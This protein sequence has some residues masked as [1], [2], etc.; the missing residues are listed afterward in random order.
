MGKWVVCPKH[1]SNEFFEQFPNCLTYRTEGK[2]W[3]ILIFYIIFIHLF[4]NLFYQRNLQLMFTGHC[5]M[6]RHRCPK[7]SDTFCHGKQLLKGSNFFIS[8][9]VEYDIR[10]MIFVKIIFIFIFFWYDEIPFLHH[11]PWN[12]FYLDF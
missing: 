5:T 7:I 12:T 3:N 10:R 11:F 9:Y 6:I 8:Q 4:F 1:S 2:Y